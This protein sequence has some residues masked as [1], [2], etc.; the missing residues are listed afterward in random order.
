MFCVRDGGNCCCES[1]ASDAKAARRFR[2]RVYEQAVRPYR[3]AV[4]RAHLRD[5][6]DLMIQ[7]TVRV[8]CAEDLLPFNP[9]SQFGLDRILSEALDSVRE[10]GEKWLVVIPDV[11]ENF[12]DLA[13]AT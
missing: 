1:D 11:R 4:M 13:D 9:I 8:R 7:H 2:M 12:Q 3:A 6:N 5:E 10:L